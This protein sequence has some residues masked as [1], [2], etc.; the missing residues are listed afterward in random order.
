MNCAKVVVS[1]MISVLRGYLQVGLCV[2]FGWKQSGV[3]LESCLF[4]YVAVIPTSPAT[5]KIWE[6]HQAGQSEYIF[7]SFFNCASWRS[8]TLLA[9]AVQI[10]NNNNKNKIMSLPEAS[11]T[12]MMR[13]VAQHRRASSTN[14]IHAAT[15]CNARQTSPWEQHTS[16]PS[17]KSHGLI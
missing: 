9:D 17:C 8:L 12:S 13:A 11:Y 15:A 3:C 4:R 6:A 14:R 1:N 2:L 10:E 5:F 16:I 7:K